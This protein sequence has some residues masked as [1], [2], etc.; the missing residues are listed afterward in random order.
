MDHR[1]QKK[2]SKYNWQIA[3]PFI[4]DQ[5]SVNYYDYL[6]NQF[7]IILEELSDTLNTFHNVD[8]SY[9]YW[10]IIVGPWLRNYLKIMINRFNTLDRAL[11]NNIVSTAVYKINSYDLVASDHLHS[12]YLSNNNVWNSVLYS[13]ILLE[14]K[15]LKF[16][17]LTLDS[18]PRIEY[19]EPWK[20]FNKK[21]VLQNI[22][23]VYR[24]ISKH[25]YRENYGVI[26]N[27]YL[28]K[29]NQVKLELSFL[30]IP[31][32][33]DTPTFDNFKVDPAVRSNFKLD[34][35]NY[36]GLEKLTRKLLIDLLP[37]CYMEGY[38]KI[39]KKIRNM[40]W[41]KDPKF[42]FT[43]NAFEFDEAF[44]FYTAKKIEEGVPYFIG[45]HGA[46]Y[47]TYKYSQKWTEITT[48]DTFIS[49]GWDNV[50]KNS[51]SVPAFNFSANKMGNL[52]NKKNGG[53]LLIKRGPGTKMDHTIAGMFI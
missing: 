44:K 46:N 41:P 53:L 16:S 20:E 33:W 2:W 52:K 15:K 4:Y 40:N 26:Y 1:R 21:G 30:Q 43:S 47:G 11:S 23:N 28:S 6:D 9:R 24:G 27:T 50:Y 49:W 22:V 17:I 12:Y 10:N 51:N 19:Q 7:D 34:Y 37:T 32:L 3:D 35:S 48:C 31:K 36:T 45:Q 14:Y 39:C 25:L 8:H 42:I 38:S 29:I 18:S 13:K 5:S